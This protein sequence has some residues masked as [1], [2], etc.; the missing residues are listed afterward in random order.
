M[1][2]LVEGSLYVFQTR[3]NSSWTS[4]HTDLWL[5]YAAFLSCLCTVSYMKKITT[6]W[7]AKAVK[8][9]AFS[10]NYCF[11]LP[12]SLSF[13]SFPLFYFFP[14]LF[15]GF[16]FFSFHFFFL[17]FFSPFSLSFLL[18]PFFFFLFPFLFFLFFTSTERSTKCAFL[19]AFQWILWG[20]NFTSVHNH[21]HMY[22]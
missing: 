3:H 11:S 10:R 15:L 1:K 17:F 6:S 18:F 14:V 21:T 12:L 16:K 22:V 4:K 7:K 13:F 5:V 19:L 9:Y 2:E 8:L 20:M